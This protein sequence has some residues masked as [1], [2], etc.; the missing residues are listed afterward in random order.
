[1]PLVGRLHVIYGNRHGLTSQQSR[2][3]I[4]ESL[5]GPCRVDCFF[6]AALHAAGP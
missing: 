2:T 1:M 3:W 5:G 4:E 6:G